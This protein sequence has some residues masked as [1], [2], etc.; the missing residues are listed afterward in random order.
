MLCDFPPEA[1][2]LGGKSNG[3]FGNPAEVGEVVLPACLTLAG[4]VLV[5][6]LLMGGS[7]R[8]MANL[9][10]NMMPIDHIMQM[11]RAAAARF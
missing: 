1:S 7:L 3:A 5:V 9:N 11:Q 6:N 2:A 4:G 10:Q 8:I